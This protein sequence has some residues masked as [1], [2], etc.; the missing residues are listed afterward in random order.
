MPHL[1]KPTPAASEDYLTTIYR[2]H[3]QGRPIIAA[4]LAET[5]EVTPATAFGMLKRLARDGL[6]Q[7][8]AGKSLSLTDKGHA[9]AEHV[10]RRHR[11]AER[12][13]TEVLNLEWHLVYEEAHLFEHAISSLVEQRLV[14]F[15]DDPATCPHGYP[16]PGHR[17]AQS[18]R[19][20]TALSALPEGARAVVARVPEDDQRLLQ[21]LGSHGF[22]PGEAIQISQVA[23]FKGTMTI[24]CEACAEKEL[25]LGQQ[26]A[27]TLLVCPS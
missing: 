18:P 3:E 2:F 9:I 14:E 22:V 6:V 4:R 16:I 17:Q 20:L 24:H 12:M 19:P 15:L 11:L 1:P 8:A 7:V 25:V 23:A 13:L 27:A 21:Y 10:V 26:V 5:V